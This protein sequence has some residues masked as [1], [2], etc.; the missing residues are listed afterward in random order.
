MKKLYS[1]FAVFSLVV[2]FA[3]KTYGC[4]GDPTNQLFEQIAELIEEH[5]IIQDNIPLILDQLLTLNE[6]GKYDNLKGKQL[7]E[8]LTTDL[9]NI[10]QDQHF[11][12]HF[13][14]ERVKDSK[15]NSSEGLQ[16]KLADDW[17]RVEKETNY[18]FSKTEILNGNIGF[19]KI[20]EFTNPEYSE[21]VFIKCLDQIKDTD[22]LII[23]LRDCIGGSGSMVWLISSYFFKKNQK[24][25]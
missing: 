14:K 23:D 22:G 20:D 15:E 9:K 17:K 19:I 16:S 10:S 5:Y 7:A 21:D 12:I 11:R 24:L 3:S 1:T 13:S 2:L 4:K 8:A 18:G 25:I 6:S